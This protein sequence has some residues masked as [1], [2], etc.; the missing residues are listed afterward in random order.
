[1]VQGIWRVCPGIDG[2]PDAGQISSPDAV[3][4]PYIK[5]LMVHRAGEYCIPEGS[6]RQVS[7]KMGAECLN[8]VL[9]FF[10]HCQKD[11]VSIAHDFFHGSF[12]E[13]GDSG[14]FLTNSFTEIISYRCG[15]VL[16]TK[17]HS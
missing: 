6:F 9:S 16:K 2:E 11:P 12:P 3:S 10:Y 13:F 4:V 14:Y 5:P 17:Y 7:L 1:M 8:C 15:G